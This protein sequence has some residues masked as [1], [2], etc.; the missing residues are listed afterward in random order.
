[1]CETLQPPC[2][3]TSSVLL[4]HV[5]GLRSRWP[6][7]G[8]TLQVTEGAITQPL[9]W[10]RQPAD[11]SII[12]LNTHTL[13]PSRAT[14]FVYWPEL[15]LRWNTAHIGPDA[16]RRCW[17]MCLSLDNTGWCLNAMCTHLHSNTLYIY[18]Q[19]LSQCILKNPDP[20]WR[21]RAEKTAITSSHYELA[22]W[23]THFQN[24]AW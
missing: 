2:Q 5:S 13:N 1:M 24:K 18:T 7:L 21:E 3:V 23:E 15:R 8:A 19:V 6:E 11:S 20:W 4:S 10:R 22:V 12:S 16:A 9:Q 17:E 14:L